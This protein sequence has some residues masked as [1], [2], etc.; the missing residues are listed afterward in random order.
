VIRLLIGCILALII[1]G[2]GLRADVMLPSNVEAYRIVFATSEETY[3]TS[4][5]IATYNS[6]VQTAAAGSGIDTAL[7]SIGITSVSWYAWGSTLTVN[8]I[9]NIKSGGADDL[10]IYNTEGQL[11]AS[12]WTQLL[13]TNS[14]PLSNPIGF[15]EN[16]NANFL[17][18]SVWTGTNYL[19]TNS[20]LPLGSTGVVSG[21]TLNST[22][23]G[24]TSDFSGGGAD[25]PHHIYAFSSPIYLPLHPVPE[26]CGFIQLGIGSV[27][28]IGVAWRR[29]KKILPYQ[30]VP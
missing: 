29:Y 5:S 28:M 24:W 19:G 26:P 9:D 8:A 14:A 16:G 7:A 4:S 12:G 13:G 20:S 17:S 25:A 3:A 10:P 23:G 22:D 11:V 27:V 1:Q 15:D 30:R 21:G 18:G 2:G 6:F